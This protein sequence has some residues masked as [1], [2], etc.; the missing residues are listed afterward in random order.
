[1]TTIDFT[2]EKLN[3]IEVLLKK[4]DNDLIG[5]M[6]QIAGLG[7]Q[8]GGLTTAYYSNMSDLKDRL[9]RIERRLEL[10]S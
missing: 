4:L 7:Q 5:V 8:V 6:V 1:M 3:R 2:L 9:D 10:V